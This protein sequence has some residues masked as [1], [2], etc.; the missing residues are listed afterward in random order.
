MQAQINNEDDG[1]FLAFCRE[2]LDGHRR[3]G[4]IGTFKSYRAKINNFEDFWDSEHGGTCKPSHLTVSL[5]NQF[6]T[7]LHEE[8]EN[9]KNT[10][11]KDL[12]VL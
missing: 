11:A 8:K 3:R 10:V 12:R 1:D 7:W 5:V 4:Q 2:V 9:A 6:E